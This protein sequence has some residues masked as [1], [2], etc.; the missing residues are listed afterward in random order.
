[1]P[2]TDKKS[3]FISFIEWLPANSVL[4]AHNAKRFDARFVVRAM[5][6]LQLIPDFQGKCFGFV[7]TLPLI[8]KLYP[9]RKSYKQGNLVKDLIDIEYD[10]HDALADVRALQA[11]IDACRITDTEAFS[12]TC[13][14]M[15]KTIA[16]SDNTKEI[17]RSLNV[18]PCEVLSDS[19]K[20]NASSGLKF[21]HMKLAYMRGGAEGV[22]GVMSEK[23]NG[24]PRVTSNK[25]ILKS[26]SDYFASVWLVFMPILND[27]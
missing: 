18:I 10:A 5:E 12:F 27:L 25:R 23:F 11:L 4:Y 16:S 6:S 3:C 1:M 15:L 26:V 20:K 19:M 8:K 2:T 9:G 13:S 21:D 7:D 24:R 17:M 14:Y 22:R